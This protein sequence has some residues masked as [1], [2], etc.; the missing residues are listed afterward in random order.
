MG[1]K[2]KNYYTPERWRKELLE[3]INFIE[4]INKRSIM[5]NNTIKITIEFPI[6]KERY[7]MY[8]Y[9]LDDFCEGLTD[10]DVKSTD[11]WIH[12]E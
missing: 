10:I 11:I 12:E 2:I 6:S 5:D 9:I 4:S 1:K 7:K 3:Q 8:S